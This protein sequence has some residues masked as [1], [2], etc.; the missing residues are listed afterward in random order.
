[1]TNLETLGRTDRADLKLNAD[2]VKDLLVR[3]IH[4][5]TTKAGFKKAVIGV[6]GGVDSAV[7]ATIA[8]EALGKENVIGVMMPYT[9]SSPS[10][11]EHAQLLIEKT[12]IRSELV[13]IGKMVDGYCEEQKITDPL[14]RGNVMARARMIVLYDISARRRWSSERA[15]RRKF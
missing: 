5:E 6:S 12:G 11:V 14:R 13:G 2:L 7:S 8:A 4:D 3:F 15:I 1:V 9:T 10:S